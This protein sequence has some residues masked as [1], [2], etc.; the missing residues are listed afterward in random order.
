MAS[1]ACNAMHPVQQRC[2]E[3]FAGDFGGGDF[4]G[5]DFGGGDFGG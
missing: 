5:G 4:G 1:T 3:A 2:A